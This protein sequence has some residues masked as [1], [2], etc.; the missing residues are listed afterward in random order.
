LRFALW[1]VNRNLL[2]EATRIV[3]ERLPFAN[4]RA[5]TH[6]RFVND[7]RDASAS[8]VALTPDRVLTAV[9][10]A[11]IAT[12]G[13]CYPLNSF[14]NRVY[15]VE[16]ADAER[17]QSSH[18][19]G[20]RVVAKFYRPGRWSG[21]QILEEHALLRELE[22]AEVPVP[23]LRAFADGSTLREIDGIRYALWERSGGRAPDE[24][25]EPLAE[26]LGMLV[27][28]LH[29]VCARRPLVHR[30]R[31]DAERYVHR[32][33]EWLERHHTLP[34][35]L[36]DR[37]VAAARG[38]AAAFDA[39]VA[40]VPYQRVHAD[41]HLGNVLMRDGMLRLL[42]FDDMAMGPPV[43]DVWLA[44][45][46]RDADSLRRRDA[47]LT[48]YEAFRTFDHTTLRLVEPLR[49]L[50]LVR[51][52]G[53]L[54]RRW[55]D[56]A[57]RAGWPHFGTVEYWRDETETLEAQLRIIHGE[58]PEVATANTTAAPAPREELLSNRDYFFDWEGD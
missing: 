21:E 49:G 8:F 45:P 50:R 19:Q 25:S 58:R 16:L 48:G 46:G 33:L 29:E 40:G 20:S 52:A 23:P 17:G 18:H 10:A 38:I 47:F 12:T 6:A 57:F 32:Q 7:D 14:E 27:G 11:G 31:L 54:A 44:V 9:E 43:Q 56:P 34:P 22:E 36:A 2:A 5:A 37:Y 26:R 3:R 42:D 30:P 4:S 55:N 51:Y 1:T 35:A 24:L 53:W 28:R 41:L 13:L 39:L 15:E